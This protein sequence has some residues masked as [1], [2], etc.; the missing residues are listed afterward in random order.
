MLQ[1]TSLFTE[2][3][4]REPAGG[5]SGTGVERDE[6]ADRKRPIHRRHAAIGARSHSTET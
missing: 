5:E 4:I 1:F 6:F 3:A 2:A